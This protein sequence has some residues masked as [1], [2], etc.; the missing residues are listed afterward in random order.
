MFIK[1]EKFRSIYF[2]IQKLLVSLSC[3]KIKSSMKKSNRNYLLK[4]RNVT[5]DRFEIV[6]FFSYTSTIMCGDDL[7]FEIDGWRENEYVNLKTAFDSFYRSLIQNATSLYK[8]ATGNDYS[9][10]FGDNKTVFQIRD[11]YTGNTYFIGRYDWRR[12]VGKSCYMYDGYIIDFKTFKESGYLH[13][14]IGTARGVYAEFE[15]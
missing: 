5:I 3:N 7:I 12:A 11:K 13:D 14:V 9:L 15:I 10:R 8:N 6:K 4:Y 1:Y 2:L